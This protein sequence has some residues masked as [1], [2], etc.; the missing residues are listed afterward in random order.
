MIIPVT[1]LIFFKIFQDFR[2]SKLLQGADGNG[3]VG[4]T[5]LSSL[6]NLLCFVI[7]EKYLELSTPH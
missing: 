6:I 2:V 4:L 1:F 5:F 7:I 3:Y